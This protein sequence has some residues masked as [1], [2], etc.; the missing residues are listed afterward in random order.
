MRSSEPKLIAVNQNGS[1]L[2]LLHD[3]IMS[4]RSRTT[5]LTSLEPIMLKT[6]RSPPI[7]LVI[8]RFIELSEEKVARPR[9]RRTR[10]LWTTLRTW[11][12]WRPG[13]N[14][15][16]DCFL[17]EAYRTALD[18]LRNNARL[19]V[20]YQS[21]ASQAF[22]FC[23]K[24]VRKT[25][26]RRLCEL[27]RQHVTT[28]AKYSHQAHA[29]NLNEPETLQ[30][31]LDTR[32]EQLN[33]A[34]ELELWQEAFRSIEDIH[35][36]LSVAKKAPKAYMMAN[37][38]EKLARIFMVG[39]NFLFHS[40]AWSKYYATVRM[41]RNLP[42]EEH[43]RMA[44]I[45][46][47]STLSIPIISNSKRS[48]Y[49]ENDDVKPRTARLT[50][51]LRVAKP[52]SRESL[53][54]EALNRSVF[55]RVR[56][57]LRELETKDL[58]KY[59]KPL[60]EVIFTRLLQ[61]LRTHSSSYTFDANFVEKFIMNGCRKG[62]LNIR[63]DHQTKS[64]TFESNIFGGSKVTI[65]EGPKLQ[66]LPSEHVRLHLTGLASRLYTAVS[67]IDTK[68]SRRL[69]ERKLAFSRRLLIEKKKEIRENQALIKARN[70]EATRQQEM[71]KAA[72]EDRIRMEEAQKAR[73]KEKLE[74]QRKAI[75][76]EEKR[77]IAEELKAK[78]KNLNLEFDL[79]NLD[80]Q[81]LRDKQLEI[82]EQER[83]DLLSKTKKLSRNV[84]HLERAFRKFELP[85][86]AKDYDN[87]KRIDRAYHEALTTAQLEASAA[88]HAEDLTIKKR[89]KKISGDYADYRK[90]LEAARDLKFKSQIAESEK[91]VEEAKAARLMEF[92]R[93]KAEALERQEREEEQR[94]IR[95]EEMRQ[96]EEERERRRAEKEIEDAKKKI[97][98]E[99]RLRKL[100][101]QAEKQRERERLAEER[102]ASSRARPPSAQ[103][104]HPP[105]T[106]ESGAAA[107]RP[108]GA[109]RGSRTAGAEPIA[110]RK[111]TLL[112]LLVR[113]A[114]PFA[115]LPQSRG[116]RTNTFPRRSD[117]P[118]LLQHRLWLAGRD[119]RSD[120][121]AAVMKD[122]A[123]DLE[124]TGE[125]GDRRRDAPVSGDGGKWRAAGP[126]PRETREGGDAAPAPWK[127]SEK[128]DAAPPATASASGK[129][130]PP[131]QR[132]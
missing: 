3:V 96:E 104:E 113:L 44:S 77:R 115:P 125:A 97:E 12:R 64:L 45:V 110:A 16:I 123:L 126:G 61:Q 106:T 70:E 114:R 15:L 59:I 49:T 17:W 60:Q 30:R 128:T 132:R 46:L 124:T 58:V 7:E 120:V 36:L 66:V 5:P 39:E 56:P 52:P 81:K 55:S 18:I 102:I 80:S 111:G 23:L 90:K 112:S 85:L 6:L 35:N 40:A 10:L 69:K 117:P 73:E 71:A 32:F 121:M 107:W 19:E 54:K 84:D 53:L 20:L 14:Y 22:K 47:L 122:E 74:A 4:K 51:L 38:Y 48:M 118:E 82:L 130:I 63:I 103:A 28:A 24:Y 21:I 87:Q 76:E 62:E 93:L 31:H 94:R 33:A 92:R 26:F 25:E 91:L 129:Y 50:N 86:W 43:Q 105:A 75:E 8:K 99:E 2:E 68:T 29:I 119:R 101:E 109:W 57:E 13:I 42:D 108:S 83:K 34:A 89:L 116:N 78:A 79:E 72:E 127:R 131:S 27:L 9:P 67:L 88:K 41:N 98:D 1:A 37:Y 65:S 95:E 100:N 11:R